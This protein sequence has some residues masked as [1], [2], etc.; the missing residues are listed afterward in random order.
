[1]AR[2]PDI[3]AGQ[4]ITAQTLRGLQFELALKDVATVRPS[5]PNVDPDP[6]LQFTLEPNARYHVEFFVQYLTNDVARFKTTW[7]VPAGAQGLK[8]VQGLGDAVDGGGDGAG[9]MRSSVHGFGTIVR[10]GWRDGDSQAWVE[11]SGSI[12]TSGGG[13]LSFN[14]AQNATS[15]YNTEVSAYSFAR[16]QRVG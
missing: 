11:E 13:T 6:D 8:R 10:Y 1:M 12:I 7:S 15:T 9:L 16:L 3:H 2:Y 5:D 4:Q 14:W